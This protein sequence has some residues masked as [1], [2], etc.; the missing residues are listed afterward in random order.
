MP[1]INAMVREFGVQEG[2]SGVAA[3]GLVYIREAHA[4]DEWP[5]A[6]APKDV[7]QPRTIQ[8]RLQ[9]ARL[10][11]ADVEMAAELWSNCYADGIDDRFDAAY[12]SWPFRFWVL[13]ASRVLL[14][15]MPQGMTY[16]LG[17]LEQ[18]LKGLRG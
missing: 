8:E 18:Y 17:E 1:R 15:P 11:L 12:A 5:I 14:K 13:N 4:V 16:D 6:E 2:G 3:F 10:L 9:A 7:R